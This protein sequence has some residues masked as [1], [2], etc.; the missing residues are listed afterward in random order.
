MEIFLWNQMRVMILEDV[1]IMSK[2][3]CSF[4]KISFCSSSSTSSNSNPKT[5]NLLTKQENSTQEVN[6]KFNLFDEEVRF[7]EINQNMDDWTIPEIPQ[8]E[9]YVPETIKQKQSS[10]YIIKTVENNIPLGQGIGEEF[11]LLSK[12]SIIEHIKKYRYLHIGCVQVAIKPLIDMGIDVVV[13]MCLRDI[14]HNKFED[15]LIGTVETSLGQGPIYF[16]CYPNKTVSLMDRNILDS[17]FLNIKFHDEVTL[18]EKWVMDK[19]AP[20]IPRP[21]PC[22]EDIRQNNSGKVEITFNRRNSFSS[23]IEASHYG[24]ARRSFSVPTSIPIGLFRSASQNRSNINFQGLDTTSN[25]PRT[26]Y[27]QEL[28]DDQKIPLEKTFTL[29]K[30]D[31][32]ENGFFNT[33]KEKKDKKIQ[34][35]FYKFIKKKYPWQ[36]EIIG[37]LNVITTWQI[38]DGELIQSKLPPTTQY[39]LPKVK[40][41]NDKPV[42]ATPFTTKDINEDI[43]PK[44]IKSLMEQANYTNK[45]LQVRGESI[46]KEATPSHVQIEKPLFKPFKVSEK[47]KKKFK[48]LRKQNFT[49]EEVGG[50]NSELLT[51]INSLLRTIPETPQ[52]SEDSHKIR[53]RQTSKLI[54]SLKKTMIRLQ[55]KHLKTLQ[56]TAPDILLEERGEGNFRSFSANNIYEWN[57]D[58]QP[59]YNIMNTLQHMSMV[60]TAYQTTHD[61][62]EETIVNILVAGFSGQLKGWWDN[63]LTNDEKTSI[64]NAIKT[65]FDGKVIINE[66][67][68]E[69]P[70][71]VNTLIF[72]IAQHF[73]GD[74]SLWKDRSA[75]LLSNLKCKTLADFRWYRDT[76]LTRVYTRED[77]QQPFWKEKFL[78]GLPRSLGDK[79]RDKIRSQSTNGDIPYDNLSYGQL[80]SYIQ[81]VAL[82]ICQD[83]KIQRQLAKE[84][85]QNKRD[86]GSFCEQFGLPTCS[87]Q[88]KKQ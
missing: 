4:S 20:S 38:K 30:T 53:T 80:I 78:A 62:S 7:E 81:K 13:L 76:F 65:D 18:P 57:I 71:A 45:Y 63:Y 56:P 28:E 17:L 52:T 88:K 25:I 19:A 14:R 8:D 15:S 9:L 43:T 48:E 3:L 84:K 67:K 12:N 22:I 11:Y 77:S 6:P 40:D 75:E 82:K 21:A 73:I 74:P 47:A 59:E 1:L 31:L 54:T 33:I 72:T 36:T 68:E 55:I 70:D 46:D 27:Q 51:K 64:Y 49:K 86:L 32:K 85:A 23:K 69:I 16:N 79:V 44:D 61:C 87:K 58:A 50:S 5:L 35:K 42:L 60:V 41:S 66:D 37:N 83:D 26:T 10:D 34:D 29:K 24:S 39:Q 2:L